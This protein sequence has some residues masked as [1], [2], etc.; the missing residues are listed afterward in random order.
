ML[1]QEF[2]V[3]A[4]HEESFEEVSALDDELYILIANG[5]LGRHHGYEHT[6]PV[7]A[8]RL[9]QLVEVVV[10]ALAIESTNAIFTLDIVHNVGVVH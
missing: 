7:R 1:L 10:S 9:V 4:L 6:G 2:N 5:L 3:R 8:Q